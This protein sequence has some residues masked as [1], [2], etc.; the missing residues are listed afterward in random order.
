M[1]DGGCQQVSYPASLRCD[2]DVSGLYQTATNSGCNAMDIDQGTFLI[3]GI[4]ID[5][6]G[7]SSI[8][9]LPRISSTTYEEAWGSAIT[10][11]NRNGGFNATSCLTLKDQYLQ[12]NISWAAQWLIGL[13]RQRSTFRLCGNRQ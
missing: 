10:I 9:S 13:Y 7:T 8:A 12:D 11:D 5:G 1:P 2:T 4:K 3:G 6:Q